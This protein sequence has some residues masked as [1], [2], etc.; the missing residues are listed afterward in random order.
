MENLKN[1]FIDQYG[2]HDDIYAFYE[3][4]NKETRPMLLDFW[5]MA[6]PLTK[7]DSIEHIGLFVMDSSIT[8][9][10]LNRN[11]NICLEFLEGGRIQ[12]IRIKAFHP[13]FEESIAPKPCI[14][15]EK[16]TSKVL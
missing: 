14:V 1:W 7:D 6:K 9:V 4:S 5:E 2:V 3:S 15:V 11:F 12:N 16:M 10:E 8:S 13:D